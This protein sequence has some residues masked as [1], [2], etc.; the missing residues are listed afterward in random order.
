MAI[1]DTAFAGGLSG[2]TWYTGTSN[3]SS[4]PGS[5]NGS[6]YL[7]TSNGSVWRLES[8]TW[9]NRGGLPTAAILGIPNLGQIPIGQGDGTSVFAD[10]LVQGIQA[11]GTTAATVNPVLVGG[12][13]GSGN[14]KDLILDS[15]GRPT[16]NVNGTVPVSAAS[17]PLPTNAAQE[18]SGNLATLAGA[19][20]STKMKVSA[21]VGDV[22]VEVS[23]GTNI[24]GTTVH[25][26]KVDPT[27]TTTQPIS[28]TVAQGTAA[29]GTAGWPITQGNVAAI[30]AAWTSATGANAAL[31]S[32]LIG[33][34]TV[35]LSLNVSGSITGG[36]LTFE[37]SDDNGTTWYPILAYRSGIAVGDSTVTLSVAGSILWQVNVTG[38]TNFRTRL[39]SVIIGTG[40]ASLRQQASSG[41]QTSPSTNIAAIAGT[42][43][44]T[45]LV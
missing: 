22:I 5:V 18:T 6:F 25:P 24:L 39:S 8:G 10:P 38:F 3:P 20:A 7:N 1:I 37:V 43:V 27:G 13:D 26:V 14:L 15:S 9:V 33:Y 31:S 41:N 16:V 28:G 34:Q 35:V 42:A 11:E 36:V 2:T 45:Q 32:A 40:T 21:A 17:L 44:L 12:K 29:T 4:I 30:T 19:V 23:D